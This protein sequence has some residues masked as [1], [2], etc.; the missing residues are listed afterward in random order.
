MNPDL[1]R[2]TKLPV[3][4]MAQLVYGRPAPRRVRLPY[5]LIFVAAFV[6]MQA[7]ATTATRQVDAP[8]AVGNLSASYN[9]IVSAPVHASTDLTPSFGA[10]DTDE[11]ATVTAKADGGGDAE[12]PEVAPKNDGVTTGAAR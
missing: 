5:R 4:S 3:V 2:T 6:A 1:L 8:E 9:S 11:D 10:V 7:C 12:L